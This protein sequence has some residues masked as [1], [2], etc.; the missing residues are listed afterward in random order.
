MSYQ[1]PLFQELRITHVP[2]ALTEKL[3]FSNLSHGVQKKKW[4]FIMSAPTQIAHIDGLNNHLYF[5]SGL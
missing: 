4:D 3:S 2:N 1:I 5:L